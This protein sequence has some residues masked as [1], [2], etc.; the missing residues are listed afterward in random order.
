MEATISLGARELCARTG[1]ESK[2]FQRAADQL[3]HVGQLSISASL[4][5]EVVKAE[6]K[7]VL[8]ASESGA[9]LP[10]WRA[11]DC[12]T[13]TPQGTEVSRVYLGI[14]GFMTPQITDAEKQKRREQVVAA[15]SKRAKDQPSL[16]PLPRR[17][18]GADQ[19]YKEIRWCNSTMS[20][21]TTG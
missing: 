3:R 15:R 10:A 4:L 19:R 8:G 14:D 21:W 13:R 2:S 17:R 5:R 7:Q 18:K 6:G 20:R 11:E 9:L 1:I 16:P 12:K